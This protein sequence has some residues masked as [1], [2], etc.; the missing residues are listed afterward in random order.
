M[1]I[2]RSLALGLLMLVLLPHA[3]R[4]TVND[5]AALCDQAAAQAAAESDVPLQVLLA[6]ARTETARNGGPWPWTV[7]MEGAGRWFDTRAEAESFAEARHAGGARSFD[8]GCFQINHRWHGRHFASIRAMF[9]PLANARYAARFLGQLFGETGS[10][11]AAVGAY[12]SRTRLHASRYLQVY[13]RHLAN[14][15]VDPP[16]A[17]RQVAGPRINGFPLLQAG[18]SSAPGSLVPAGAGTGRPLFGPRP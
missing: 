7:N 9:D 13:H 6:I 10:W 4:A 2:A 16:P 17:P 14:L 8:I 3:V 12:H 15:Q 11:D 18:T 1:P 5:D